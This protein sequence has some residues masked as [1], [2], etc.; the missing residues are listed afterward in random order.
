MLALDDRMGI[1][2]GTLL[3]VGVGA[4][5]ELVTVTSLPALS[6][7]APDPGNV[8]VI[9]G[10]SA[11]AADGTTV[12]D[13]RRGRRRRGPASDRAGAS[14]RRAARPRSVVS[15][16]QNF[17]DAEIVRLTIGAQRHVPPAHRQRHA[18]HRCECAG[19]RPPL[20]VTLATALAART[21]PGPRSSPATRWSTSRRSTRA[22]GA[23]GSG[24]ASTDETPGL[25][26]RDDA[27]H[28]R[29]PDHGPARLRGRACSPA[30]CSS[31]VTPPTGAVSAIP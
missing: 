18:A 3:E 29:Q 13:P 16:G 2:E 11:A 26:S 9:P 30:P 15:D 28:V 14:R 24:S 20:D 10:L 6:G 22:S 1:A 23:T 12:V 19:R 7:I 21:R 31:S 4:A 8:V 27:R 25:V 17:A 5:A